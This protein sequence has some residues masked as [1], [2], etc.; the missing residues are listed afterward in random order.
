MLSSAYF[1][2]KFR[3]D[4]AESDSAK[5]LQILLILLAL[6]VADRQAELRRGD[7]P[8]PRVEARLR[9]Y[10]VRQRLPTRGKRWGLQRR[11]PGLNL[12]FER[13]LNC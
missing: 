3:F 7:L 8:H 11:M 1:L 5:N 6:G 2:A 10:G 13:D 4:T 12:G 9:C